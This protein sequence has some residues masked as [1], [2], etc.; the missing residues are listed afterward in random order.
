M[1]L[2]IGECSTYRP[3]DCLFCLVC[4][5][6]VGFDWSNYVRDVPFI[7]TVTTHFST[8]KDVALLPLPGSTSC[9]CTPLGYEYTVVL[10]QVQV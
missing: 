7:A 5:D 4:F 9:T 10:V 6:C 8:S 2:I 3:L 1:I